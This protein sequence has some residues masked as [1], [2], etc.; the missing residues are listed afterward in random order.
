V[1]V[2][3]TP[4][5][6]VEG[7]VT[8]VVDFGAFI[9]LEPGVEGLLHN[10]EFM[11]F[12]QREELEQGQDLLVKI[13]RI[14]PNR[15]RIGL[16]VRQVRPI[17]WENWVV[18]HMDLGESD[19]SSQA[20]EVEEEDVVE[21]SEDESVAEVAEDTAVETE[22]EAVEETQDSDETSDEEASEEESPEGDED[23]S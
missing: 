21:A 17:E 1:D 4:G 19:A 11:D 12:A 20:E 9:E 15:R 5:D 6:L 13:I 18:S 22:A 3:Y 2:N 14:E 23:A 16:S 8:Q 10:S 7:K